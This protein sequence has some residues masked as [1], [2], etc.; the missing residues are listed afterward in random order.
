MKKLFSLLLAATMTFSLTLPALADH[1]TY[2]EPEKST[3]MPRSTPETHGMSSRYILDLLDAFDYADAEVHNILMAIDGEVV[4]EGHYAPYTALDPHIMFSGTKIFTNAAV[5]VA[6]T[7]GYLHLDDYV[8]DVLKDYVTQDVS[9]LQ[10]KVQ[11]KHLLTMTSGVDRFMSGSELRPLTTSWI[12]HILTE[13]IVHEP[14]T[15]YLYSSG[16][17]M[18]SSAMV[19]VATGKTCLELLNTTGFC[20]ELGI[21]NFTWDMSPDGFNAGHGGIK[22]TAE[23]LAKVGQLYMNGGVWNGKQILSKEWCDLAIGYEKTVENQGAYAYHWTAY[24]DGLYYTATGS[25][26]QT[27]AICPKLNMVIAIQAGTKQNIGELLYQNIFKPYGDALDAGTVP[28]PDDALSAA[29]AKRAENLNLMFTTDFTASPIGELVDDV[30]F[31]AAENQYG[32]TTLSLDV[33]DDYI[34]YTMTDAR[35]T[36]TIRNGIWQWLK[37]ETS[38]TSNYTHHQYQYPTEPVYAYAEWKDANTLQLTWRFPELAFVDTLTLTFS[39]DGSQ[40]GMVRSVNVNSG[41]LVC[42]E[43]VFTK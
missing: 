31:T 17:T 12:E 6:V 8:Y 19:T 25:Y 11:L 22:I 2:S 38:M 10:S 21:K 3:M 27:L 26:G 41:P 1:Y 42:D 43:V 40:I 35:G 4:F 39:D 18:L 9:E 24:E 28:E 30:T 36:H 16:N 14:G 7:E 37:G 34:D 29:L 15:Y 23:D 33:H 32:I 13:P 5:G 20:E